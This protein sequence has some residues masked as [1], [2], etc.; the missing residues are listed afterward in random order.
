[1][2]IVYAA[3]V[4]STD[5]DDG[6]DSSET[7]EFTRLAPAERWI[8]THADRYLG[9]SIDVLE[10]RKVRGRPVD[11][12]TAQRIYQ[13]TDARTGFVLDEVVEVAS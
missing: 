11:T 5:T 12:L 7:V 9:A 2:S 8:D 4:N 13:L 10:R 3:T 1:M 6:L